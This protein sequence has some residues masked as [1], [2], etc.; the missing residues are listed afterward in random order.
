MLIAV[1][2]NDRHLILEKKSLMNCRELFHYPFVALNFTP[3]GSKLSSP[4]LMFSK[5][6]SSMVI[7]FYVPYSSNL[8]NSKSIEYPESFFNC[9]PPIKLKGIYENEKNNQIVT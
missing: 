5:S 3:R 7:I 2:S 8:E 1:F 4:L 6:S 9:S